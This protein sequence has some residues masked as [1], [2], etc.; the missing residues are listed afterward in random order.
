MK[1]TLVCVICFFQF[2]SPFDVHAKLTM[3]SYN[4][5]NFD[6]D[7]R[8]RVPTN[9]NKLYQTLTQVNADLLAVQEI[10]QTEVFKNFIDRKFFGRYGVALSECGGA[11]DQRLGFVYDKAKFQL[12]S[13]REDLRISNPQAPNQGFCQR[14]SRPLAIGVF[15]IKDSGKTFVA[16]SVHLK[17]GGQERSIQKRF[18]QL[19]LL[20]TVMDEHRSRGFDN[21]A[22]MGDFNTTEYR[23][24][25]RVYRD[26]KNMLA[27]MNVKDAS[28]AVKCT[29]Y[30]W[31]GKPDGK[32]Y[33]S[34]LDHILLSGSF[35]KSAKGSAQA[36]VY[37]HCA[38]LDCSAAPKEDLG[39]V[40][41]QVSDHCPLSLSI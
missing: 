33:P 31:G 6:Y 22:L 36:K 3:A 37:G 27:K 14:G 1:L 28:A 8:S 25:G 4:I 15:K 9:K 23:D 38:K 16:F 40:Y 7:Q 20:K 41:N 19:K 10:N 21:F 35:L 24:A 29:S 12:I 26:F 18:K 17:S 30:W 13:F 2:L 11:H 34:K 5:R 32:E 39:A